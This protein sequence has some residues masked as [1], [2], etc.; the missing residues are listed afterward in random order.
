MY[1]QTRFE[2]PLDQSLHF[3]FA[4]TRILACTGVCKKEQWWGGVME[5]TL[6]GDNKPRVRWHVKRK[7]YERRPKL[8]LAFPSKVR[9]AMA[10]VQKS[11][12]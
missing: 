2:N 5:A 10:D 8:A 3:R 12:Y 6:V 11:P 7:S 9:T 1:F 4:E